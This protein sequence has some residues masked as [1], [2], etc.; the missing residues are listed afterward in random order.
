VAVTVELIF[1]LA[2]ERVPERPCLRYPQAAWL[3]ATEFLF[4]ESFNELAVVRLLNGEAK[5][6]QEQRKH[7]PVR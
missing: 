4:R 6:P 5:G 2:V 1:V 3:N 7:V